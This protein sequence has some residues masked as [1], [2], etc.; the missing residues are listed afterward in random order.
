[1]FNGGGQEWKVCER[2]NNFK[3]EN[4]KQKGVRFTGRY[5]R[6]KANFRERTSDRK[7]KIVTQRVIVSRIT[8]EKNL[9]GEIFVSFI[10]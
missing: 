7:I 6:E 1:M 2:E 10:L 9:I 8:Q 5:M 3:V 4:L